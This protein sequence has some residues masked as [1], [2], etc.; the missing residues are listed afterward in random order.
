MCPVDLGLSLNNVGRHSKCNVFYIWEDFPDT[1]RVS[2]IGEMKVGSLPEQR[3]LGCT[4][5]NPVSGDLLR[6]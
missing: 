4:G 5:C 6:E 2:P 1:A 3:L